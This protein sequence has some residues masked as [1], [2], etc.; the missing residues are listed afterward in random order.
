MFNQYPALVFLILCLTNIFLPRFRLSLSPNLFHVDRSSCVESKTVTNLICKLWLIVSIFVTAQRLRVQSSYIDIIIWYICNAHYLYSLFHV[1][2]LF[3]QVIN[4]ESTL[5]LYC[6]S[7]TTEKIY[8]FYSFELS[9]T[10]QQNNS[11]YILILYMSLLRV[12]VNYFSLP[13]L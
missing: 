13:S 9:C 1:K 3:I 5:V 7:L 8:L 6:V 4:K 12:S 10:Q 2:N 11:L